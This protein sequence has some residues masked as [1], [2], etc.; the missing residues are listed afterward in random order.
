VY[1]FHNVG[2]VTSFVIMCVYRLGDIAVDS[3]IPGDLFSVKRA[4]DLPDAR[5][6][7]HADDLSRKVY[8]TCLL[9]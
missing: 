3:V 6:S 5:D 4:H 2:I 1:S 7:S 9:V 8:S